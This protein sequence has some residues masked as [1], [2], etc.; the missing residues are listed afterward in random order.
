[1][2][3]GCNGVGG[4]GLNMWYGRDGRLLVVEVVVVVAKVELVI[5]GSCDGGGECDGDGGG[6]DCS[7][8]CRLV[9]MAVLLVV[10]VV[11]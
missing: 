5:F 6:D 2:V 11:W 9:A 10:V 1:M 8:S 4:G 3:V 7:C